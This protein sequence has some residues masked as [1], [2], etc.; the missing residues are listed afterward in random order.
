MPARVFAF[1]PTGAL[2]RAA[3]R[4]R[5]PH[6][7]RPCGDYRGYVAQRHDCPGYPLH[8]TQHAEEYRQSPLVGTYIR[9]VR[10]FGHLAVLAGQPLWLA[11]LTSRNPCCR[12]ACLSSAPVKWAWSR[13]LSVFFPENRHR[14]H[15]DG[16]HSYAVSIG[17]RPGDHRRLSHRRC[18]MSVGLLV[19]EVILYMSAAVP[20]AVLPLPAWSSTKALSSFGCCCWRWRRCFRCRGAAGLLLLLVGRRAPGL[21]AFPFI[22]L[23]GLSTPRRCWPSSC[24]NL[25][26]SAKSRPSIVKPR[27]EDRL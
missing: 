26:P 9:W 10:S 21:L 22:C 23:L 8:H 11:L 15:Q 16:Y 17:Y 18:N 3:R 12:R 14:H 13:C 6:S 19:P 24:A 20:L 1:P 2:H 4:S 25:F 5:S 27:D 7:G